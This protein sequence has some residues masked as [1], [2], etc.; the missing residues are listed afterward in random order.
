MILTHVIKEFR[1]RN[2]FLSNF[3]EGEPFVFKGMKFTNVESAF[4]SQKDIS[5]QHEFEMIRPSQSKRL[6]RS[7]NLRDDW[8]E[9]KY[10]IMYDI[11]Y[12]KF[13][14]SETLKERLLN[15][16]YEYI[17]E[18][19][20]WHDNEW[21]DCYCSRCIN[22]KGENKLGEILMKVRE[23]LRDENKA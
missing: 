1:G 11:C 10:N 2:F 3:Y 4:Q 15:T 12:A 16:Q 7:V 21:G 5:R 14:Q 22:L 6:G 23:V 20:T 9:V 18:G 19:N 8:E 13:S 17:I